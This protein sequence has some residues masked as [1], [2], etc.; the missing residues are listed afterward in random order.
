MDHNT[1]PHPT[2]FTL[3]TR[4][5]YGVCC[6][7]R[8][9][10]VRRRCF[11]R[12]VDGIVNSM[13]SVCSE[14]SNHICSQ[15]I[16]FFQGVPEIG[17]AGWRFKNQPRLRLCHSFRSS[18]PTKLSMS[19]PLFRW[20]IWSWDILSTSLQTLYGYAPI[21]HSSAGRD[22]TYTAKTSS[23]VSGSRPFT[24]TLRIPDTQPANWSLHCICCLGIILYLADH[25]EDLRLDQYLGNIV[26]VL[27]FGR[28][29]WIAGH[30]HR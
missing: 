1:S 21:T 29:R 2:A 28:R 6:R 30:T 13:Y 3:H 4:S 17:H 12:A 10:F 16:W 26:R 18:W 11:W 14:N 19:L 24:I 27:E 22:F 25:L 8:L 15:K 5:T 23:N 9:V 7:L 20:W